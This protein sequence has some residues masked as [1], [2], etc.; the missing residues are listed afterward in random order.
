[1][2][3]P[4]TGKEFLQ[5]LVDLTG[6]DSGDPRLA[7][8]KWRTAGSNGVRVQSQTSAY[9]AIKAAKAFSAE[10]KMHVLRMGNQETLRL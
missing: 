2:L 6:M 4:E 7:L 10:Q 5:G 8:I 1:M 3:Y 9:A